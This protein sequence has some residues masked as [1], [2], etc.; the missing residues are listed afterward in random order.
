MAERYNPNSLNRS[1][2]IIGLTQE[3]SKEDFSSP[4]INGIIQLP[5]TDEK[6]NQVLLKWAGHKS[7]EGMPL[8]PESPGG[9]TR[10]A[11]S[12]STGKTKENTEE[13]LSLLVKYST[14][15]P[16]QQNYSNRVSQAD[17][18]DG[19]LESFC[20][21]STLHNNQSGPPYQQPCHLG[22]LIPVNR[23]SFADLSQNNQ[24]TEEDRLHH[25]NSNTAS[26]Q[27][28]LIGGNQIQNQPLSSLILQRSAPDHMPTQEDHVSVHVPPNAVNTVYP[29]HYNHTYY[30]IQATDQNRPNTIPPHFVAI[31]PPPLHPNTRVQNP[32]GL[33]SQAAPKAD[34]SVVTT[35]A[36][37]DGEGGKIVGSPAYMISGQLGSKDMK[38]TLLHDD[39]SKHSSKERIRRERIK[40][41]CDQLRFL[42]P[43]VA[44]K[45][46]DMASILEMTVK[47]VRMI[48]ERLPPA[49][50]QEISQNIADTT[51]I[52]PR[53]RNKELSANTK[54]ARPRFAPPA[55]VCEGP[56]G[57]PH[58]LPPFYMR[59]A[60]FQGKAP[61]IVTT[62][63]PMYVPH[64]HIRPSHEHT[65]IPLQQHHI[66]QP[67]PA[68]FRLA[69]SPPSVFNSCNNGNT[70][71][72]TN[73]FQHQSAHEHVTINP[74]QDY[75]AT[76]SSFHSKHIYHGNHPP[77]PPVPGHNYDMPQQ[78]SF[79]KLPPIGN[80]FHSLGSGNLSQESV[81][82]DPSESGRST[83]TDPSSMT[84]PLWESSGNLMSSGRQDHAHI[85]SPVMF[86]G[87]SM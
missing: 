51:T 13:T 18:S 7:C 48:K 33:T 22:Q 19:T 6:V 5:V 16:I 34:L 82:H 45:K 17:N 59:S 12:K 31:N 24:V 41:S 44:G 84:P 74:H 21:V 42:L 62:T 20:K 32:G 87:T 25:Q 80:I 53:K 61:A 26:P 72:G 60:P 9:K 85:N 36:S 55:N 77:I 73:T 70:V 1:V 69:A 50:L 63:G 49:V 86:K 65:Q 10:S 27:N 35:Q 52:L 23:N 2:A 78:W 68:S 14:P 37:P 29:E 67:E 57:L 75:N 81:K 83:P 64:L 71:R 76:H 40:E 79:L 66:H 8:T 47:Y 56:P 54:Q 4:E 46:S 58:P 3:G 43:S 39:L 38:I 15:L 28:F 30:H 11:V